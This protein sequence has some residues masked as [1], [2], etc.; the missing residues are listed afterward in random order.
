MT[1]VFRHLVNS[2]L[3]CFLASGL[4]LVNYQ[5]AVGGYRDKRNTSAVVSLGRSFTLKHGREVM[6]KGEK[7]RIKFAAV[8]SDSRCPSDV[9]CIWAGNAAV[10]L[11][12]ST[13]RRSRESVTL[14]TSKAS[15]FGTD[16]VFDGYKLQLVGLA[17][18]PRSS[19]KI[20]D[21]EYTATLIVSKES[22]TS[23]TTKLSSRQRREMFIATTI[24]NDF[25]AP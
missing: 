23:K 20:E 12:V 18:Y 3:I 14:N 21:S 16:K 13:N 5:S 17:P 8:E 15:A 2:G 24:R 4:V 11:E 10:R 9:T 19:Q 7:L 6:L 1:R 25:L 22:A